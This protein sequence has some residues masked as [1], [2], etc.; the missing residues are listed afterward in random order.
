MAPVGRRW[1][2][3]RWL[4]S[5]VRDGSVFKHLY[6]RLRDV[7]SDIVHIWTDILAGISYRYQTVLVLSA[8]H[9]LCNNNNVISVV[10][11]LESLLEKWAD[12]RVDGQDVAGEAVEAR[13]Q[14]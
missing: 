4:P 1:C 8:L 10:N 2:C 7:E 5:L 13:D 3:S 9:C 12:F 6:F 14:C 11:I